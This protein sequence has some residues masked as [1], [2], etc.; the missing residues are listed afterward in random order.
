M[1]GDYQSV[2]QCWR[3]PRVLQMYK[4]R[5]RA[6][7]S[8]AGAQR[9]PETGHSASAG[10]QQITMPASHR[11][12]LCGGDIRSIGKERQEGRVMSEAR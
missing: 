1:F 11:L 6:I 2:K 8:G 12:F 7:G 5:S 3:E 10:N 9:Q 4:L